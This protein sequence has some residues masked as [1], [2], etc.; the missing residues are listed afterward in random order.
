[1]RHLLVFCIVL[2]ANVATY[3][4]ERKNYPDSLFSTYYHQRVSHFK[5]LPHSS[6]DIVFLGNSITD[7]AEWGELFDNDHIKNRGISGDVSAGVINRLDEVLSVPPAKIFLLIGINDLSRNINVDSIWKNYQ[8]IIHLIKNKSSYTKIYVQSILPVTDV[9]KKFSGHTNKTDS[10]IK[11]NT[12]A[13]N[14]QLNGEYTFIDLYSKFCDPHGKLNAALTNDGLH[15]KGEGYVLWKHLLYPYVND[16][17][18]NASVLPSLKKI[19]WNNELFPL[20]KLDTIFVNNTTIST[21]DL[22]F[23][24]QKKI[25]VVHE[26]TAVKNKTVLK[27]LLGNVD[28][29]LLQEEAYTIRVDSMVAEI[30]A[31]TVKGLFY[32]LQT[33]KQLAR[34]KVMI[35]GCSIVDWPS[36]SWRAYMTDVGRNYETIDLLKQQIDVMSNY[37]MNVFH[38]HPTEDI[39]WRWQI[40]QYPQLT[41]P[42][43][44]LR[45]KGMY[46]SEEEIKDLI[47]YCEDRFITFVPE[48]DMPGHSAAFTRAMNVSMQS[49]KGK[50][51]IKNILS[52]VLAT[53][54][55]KYFH[56][57]GDEVKITDTGFIPSMKKELVK[58]NVQVIGWKPG[59]NFTSNT[60]MQLWKGD[61]KVEKGFRYIDSRHL[62][63]NHFDPLESV[64]AIFNR[65]IGNVNQQTKE[66][67]GAELCLWHDRNVVTEKDMMQMN[68]VYPSMI[69]F[70]E[71]A[72]N[73]NGSDEFITNIAKEDTTQLLKFSFFEKQLIEHKKL[74]FKQRPF[75]YFYQS[76]TEWKLAGP[77][78][79]KGNLAKQFSPEEENF[80]VVYAATNKTAIGKTVV[81]QHFWSPIIKGVLTSSNTNTT[82]YAL[83]KF[84][85]D[86]EKQM[87]CWVG[88]NNFSRST[89]TDVPAKGT[90]DNKMSCLWVNGI[91]ILSP[92]WIRANQKGNIEIPL[93]DEG[94]EYRR[95]TK[96]LFHKGWNNVL[97]KLPVGN[98]QGHDWQ[99][100]VKWMFTFT[101]VSD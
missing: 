77:F 92:S 19:E 58:K 35:D 31:N 47:K 55:L 93:M 59:G 72:W 98:F 89:G 36:F 34:D 17:E 68:P 62:Y 18:P 80:D 82:W 32:A 2:L 45:N 70:A 39:A 57:G 86:E 83:G 37:K 23:F 12:I 65:K 76:S 16:V 38:F 52:E 95:S 49:E 87:P 73:G 9:Y 91:K 30:K 64:V 5:T 75:A 4:Q 3:T 14:N 54:R 96:V 20:W 60:I 28:A 25:V 6:N 27:L 53:Y 90:W 7:G 67:L 43:N 21:F 22:P 41:Q 56:I 51:I 69:A 33:F 10:I 46:Y 66:V 48:I 71:K 94:Y 1:M 44:M 24:L 11:L 99:N 88:F 63:I 78:N 40:K 79:N 8:Y 84:W 74:Y 15:L 85:S 97:V 50:E 101:P 81:L 42:E 100:P 26:E 29:P 13:R 61:E